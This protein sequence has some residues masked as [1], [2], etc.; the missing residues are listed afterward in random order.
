[1]SDVTVEIRAETIGGEHFVTMTTDDAE[2][3]R[4]GP[5]AEY[6]DALLWAKY[7][8]AKATAFVQKKSEI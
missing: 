6:P 3:G 4:W 1:M 7:L 8:A 5:Y 2:S